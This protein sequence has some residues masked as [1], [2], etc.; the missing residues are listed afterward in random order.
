V[1]A[2]DDPQVAELVATIA[3][4]IDALTRLTTLSERVLDRE[5]NGPVRCTYSS[6]AQAARSYLCKNPPGRSRRITVIDG[7]FVHAVDDVHPFGG[8]KSKRRSVSL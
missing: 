4:L 8:S 7:D 5:A 3:A 1:V 6:W 2:D